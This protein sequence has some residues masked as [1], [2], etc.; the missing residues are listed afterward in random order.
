MSDLNSQYNSNT[1]LLGIPETGTNY[2]DTNLADN[3]QSFSFENNETLPVDQINENQKRSNPY[4]HWGGFDDHDERAVKMAKLDESAYG[5]PELLNYR[6]PNLS[7]CESDLS[8]YG[9]PDNNKQDEI[10]GQIP[11]QA[12]RPYI[13]DEQLPSQQIDEQLP[14]QEIKPCNIVDQPSLQMVDH[15]EIHKQPS[16]QVV[17]QYEVEDQAPLQDIKHHEI[18]NQI[19]LHEIKQYDISAQSPLQEDKR[20]ELSDKSPLQDIKPLEIIDQLSLQDTEQY[21]VDDQLSQDTIQNDF[22]EESS[23]QN[24]NPFIIEEKPSLQDIKPTSLQNLLKYEVDEQSLQD[25]KPNLQDIKPIQQDIKPNLQD[26]KPSPT[27]DSDEV[28]VIDLTEDDDPPLIS[29]TSTSLSALTTSTIIKQEPISTTSLFPPLNLSNL[30]RPLFPNNNSLFP[31]VNNFQFPTINNNITFPNANN[32]IPQNVNSPIPSNVNGNLLFNF[33]NSP[34][35]NETKPNMF[36]NRQGSYSKSINLQDLLE[37]IPLDESNK[38]PVNE[39]MRKINARRGIVPGLSSIKLMDHQVI[40]VSW[41]VDQEIKDKVRGGILA[42]DMGLGKTV[43]T[44]ATIVINRPEVKKSK[45]SAKSTLIVAPTALIYQWKSEILSKTDQDLFSVH[46]YHGQNKASFHN[47]KKHDIVITTYQTLL[48]EW[49]ENDD[50]DD[51]GSLFRINWFRVVLDEA[52]N[53]KN[54]HSRASTP[55]QNHIDDLYPYFRFLEISN[56]SDWQTFHEQFSSGSQRAIQRAQTVLRGFL[57]RRT[58]ESKLDGKPLLVLPDKSVSFVKQDFSQD[59]REFYDALEKRSRIEFNHYLK[60]GS[61]LKN[62][63][64]ILVMLLRLRQACNHPFLTQE[65]I[66]HIISLAGDSRLPHNSS[67]SNCLDKDLPTQLERAKKILS[68]KVITRLYDQYKNSSSNDDCPICYDLIDNGIV[69]SCGHV[70]CLDCIKNAI[71]SENKENVID[72]E[73]RKCPICR[74]LIKE[75]DFISLEVFI[76]PVKKETQDDD[77]DNELPTMDEVISSSFTGSDDSLFTSKEED[78]KKDIDAT[79]NNATNNTFANATEGSFLF[80][81]KINQ[82]MKELAAAQ[83]EDPGCKTIVFSQWT[84]MLDLVE[85]P[86]KEAGYKFCRYDGTMDVKER[87]NSLTQLTQDNEVTIMLVSLKAGGVGLN[88]TKANRVIM[89]D[90][91]WNPAVEDQAIDR[92]HRI[93]QFK[94]VIIKRLTIK[95]TIED[96]ILILQDKKRELAAGALGE[97]SIKVG[98]LTVEDL[99]FLFR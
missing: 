67:N 92:V 85:K 74:S 58:K 19:S 27:F 76:P 22:D 2:Y 20:F 24:I 33:N 64:Y 16:L 52:Q 60:E 3:S 32:I 73:D 99:I 65:D 89:L 17:K 9:E 57:L 41:M 39:A 68:D 96:R 95:D 1:V 78:P 23:L 98:R 48:R 26:I 93:G 50:D 54:R 45:S 91:W 84:S 35:P 14:L 12:I 83:Q 13:I 47:L 88:L 80:S 6:E 90:C 79:N 69:T 34:L 49:P 11:L 87:D 77:D 31:P 86:I 71:D 7:S 53:I 8:L 63:A 18:D 81:T 37:M 70:F 94:N 5:G 28:E 25:I 42:D 44:I 59:E 36:E 82:L 55:I 61:V 4:M 56:F 43:Q 40:G 30:S 75:R 10:D 29:S 51:R 66:G 46:V 15:Y 38:T 62:Y 21:D 97:G 72:V